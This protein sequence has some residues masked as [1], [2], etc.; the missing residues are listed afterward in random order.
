L[1]LGVFL[2]VRSVIFVRNAQ[3]ADAVVTHM[4]VSHSTRE[5]GEQSRDI[6]RPTFRYKDANQREHTVELGYYSSEFDY[7][8]GEHVT[9]LYDPA[10][11]GW[12]GVDSFWAIWG[13]AIAVLV[14]G[15]GSAFFALVITLA[16]KNV[17]TN[18]NKRQR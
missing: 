17:H 13:V 7:E 16:L 3:R 8:V 18:D 5:P 14:L 11:P 1:V 15:A 2:L 9:I 4:E 10:N 6:Y 12:V